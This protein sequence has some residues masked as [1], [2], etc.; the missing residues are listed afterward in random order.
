MALRI[1][2]N[3]IIS[4]VGRMIQSCLYRKV[5]RYNAKNLLV[6][7]AITQLMKLLMQQI[8]KINMILGEGANN[9]RW[10]IVV[11]PRSLIIVAF[12]HTTL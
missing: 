2:E 3:A 8:Q 9:S 12:M 1:R 7:N 5:S 4:L 10:T 6:G 11:F